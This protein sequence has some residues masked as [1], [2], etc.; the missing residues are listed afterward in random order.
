MK[1]KKK[2]KASFDGILTLAG[3]QLPYSILNNGDNVIPIDTKDGAIYFV[4]VKPK[5]AETILIPVDKSTQEGKRILYL[6]THGQEKQGIKL[7][8]FL[9][10]L[11]ESV[12]SGSELVVEVVKALLKEAARNSFTG[13]FQDLKGDVR[14]SK[15]K[16]D[17]T[18]DF[19]NASFDD[20]V[21][22]LVNPKS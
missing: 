22:S 8:Q 16:I 17:K 14:T 6:D 19:G 10:A 21:H 20:L 15:G 7:Q 1:A 11:L 18:K 3:I 4:I 9:D 12:S 13:Y 2:F 5:K